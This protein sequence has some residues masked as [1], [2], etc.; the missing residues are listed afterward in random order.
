VIGKGGAM[1]KEVGTKARQELEWLLG[2]KVFLTLHVKVAKDWQKDP[3]ALQR[4]GY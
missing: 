1:L 4:L 2:A 3:R